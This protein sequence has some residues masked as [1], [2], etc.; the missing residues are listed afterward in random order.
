MIGHALFG[1]ILILGGSAG[2][3][4]LKT[5]VSGNTFFGNLFVWKCHI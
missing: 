1:C 5:A 4:W 3:N 2:F